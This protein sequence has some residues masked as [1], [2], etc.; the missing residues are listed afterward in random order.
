MCVMCNI[1]EDLLFSVYVNKDCVHDDMTCNTD[2]TSRKMLEGERGHC[3]RRLDTE[4]LFGS[5][6]VSHLLLNVCLVTPPTS[7][8]NLQRP[9]NQNVNLFFKLKF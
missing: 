4:P 9:A 6:W 2:A 7:I 8:L 1:I 5:L 3:C